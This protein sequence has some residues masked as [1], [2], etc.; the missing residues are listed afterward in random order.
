MATPP[1]P[2]T[3]FAWTVPTFVTLTWG[4]QGPVTL[5]WTVQGPNVNVTGSLDFSVPE[6]SQFLPGL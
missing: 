3:I 1:V 2:D 4:V 5:D 6:N